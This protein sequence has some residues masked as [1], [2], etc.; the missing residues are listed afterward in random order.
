MQY[1]SK[2][3]SQV[4]TALKEMQIALEIKVRKLFDSN[5]HVI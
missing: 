2:I 4:E 5:M 1:H 3:D